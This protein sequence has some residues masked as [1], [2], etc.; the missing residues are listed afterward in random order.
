MTA[1]GAE[2]GS[3]LAP[4]G[5]ATSAGSRGAELS[6]ARV[7]PARRRLVRAVLAIALALLAALAAWFLL[8]H[9]I[10]T[11]AFPPFIAG[12]QVTPITRYSGPWL[13]A[14]AGM[15]LVAALFLLFGVIDLSRWSRA[16]RM[17]R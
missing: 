2:A 11:D 10:R 5:P 1:T 15:A 4:V 9:G 16:K 17:G 7:V 8:R 6:V 3:D 14:A 12:E 13:T